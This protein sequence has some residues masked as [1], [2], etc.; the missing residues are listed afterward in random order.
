MR[1]VSVSARAAVS[2]EIAWRLLTDV[3]AYPGRVRFVRRIRLHG[4]LIVGARWD[5][6]TTILGLPLWF[7]HTVTRLNPPY[8]VAFAVH[9]PGGGTMTQTF[10][11]CRAGSATILHARICFALA[12]PLVDAVLGP[13]LERRLLAMLTTSIDA[14]RCALPAA[15]EEEPCWPHAS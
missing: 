4:P 6:Q 1:I 7:R 3:G 9:L 2:R 14:A 15:Q 8:T 11:L 13:L 10:T 5:D 12:P